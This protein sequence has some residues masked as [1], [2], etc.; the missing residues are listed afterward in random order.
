MGGVPQPSP[1]ARAALSAAL[2]AALLIVVVAVAGCSGSSSGA[3]SQGPPS[4]G[5]GT[6]PNGATSP[7]ATT[8]VE[9]GTTPPGTTLKL[10]KQAVVRYTANAAHDSVIKLTVEKV[11]KGKLKDLKEFQLSNAAKKSSVYYVTARVKNSGDGDLSGQPLQLYGK[12]SNDLV[13][14]PVIM[15]STFKKCDY[16]PLPSPFKPG[17]RTTVCVLLLAPHHGQV[18]AVQW[19]SADDSKPITWKTRH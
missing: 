8:S 10:G 15:G 1:R 18:K 12:V 17:D 9:P 7:S 3:T 13:V 16:Q 2:S 4:S 14:P 11:K 6:S 19:R 5:S